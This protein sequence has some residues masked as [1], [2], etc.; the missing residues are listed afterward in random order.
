MMKSSAN[1][2]SGSGGEK[3]PFTGD[4]RRELETLKK[5]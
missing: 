3:S 1:A 2:K 5:T 4:A